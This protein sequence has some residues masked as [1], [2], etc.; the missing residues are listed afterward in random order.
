M[1]PQL[2]I[3]KKTNETPLI[4]IL[5]SQKLL[6]SL[7]EL[8]E[9]EHEEFQRK[10]WIREQLNIDRWLDSFKGKIKGLINSKELELEEIFKQLE[11]LLL[12]F[13]MTIDYLRRSKEKPV[14]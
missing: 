8:L 2:Q 14:N 13:V 1:K 7:L 6:W 12:V 9:I 3:P 5:N 10:I 11:D 4:E